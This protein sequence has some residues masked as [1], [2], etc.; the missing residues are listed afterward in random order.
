MKVIFRF[1]KKK[2]GIEKI[3]VIELVYVTGEK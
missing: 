1:S 3:Q 2:F